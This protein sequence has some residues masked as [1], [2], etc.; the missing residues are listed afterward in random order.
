MVDES[1]MVRLRR[2]SLPCHPRI[3][4]CSNRVR[5]PQTPG[6]CFSHSAIDAG[7]D[8]N[9]LVNTYFKILRLTSLFEELGLSA[10][11][12]FVNLK[13]L[14]ILRATKNKVSVLSGIE[15]TS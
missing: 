2:F 4:T 3:S 12:C 13:F 1:P 10:N 6:I 5:C 14:A 9:V 7:L 15:H 8:F 11:N